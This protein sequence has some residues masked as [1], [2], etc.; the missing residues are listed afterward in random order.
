MARATTIAKTTAPARGKTSAASTSGSFAP[1]AADEASLDA[2]DLVPGDGIA[3]TGPWI[4]ESNAEGVLADAKRL[5][6]YWDSRTPSG[7]LARDVDDH[8][9][10]AILAALER[11]AK[12]DARPE[13]L[14][15]YMSRAALAAASK[16]PQRERCEDV[17]ARKVLFAWENTFAQENGRLATPA[18]RDD[19][20]AEIVANWP[21]KRHKPSA[22]FHSS[23]YGVKEVSLSDENAGHIENL[24]ARPASSQPR[25]GSLLDSAMDLVE[26]ENA[27]TADWFRLRRNAWNALAEINEAPMVT[28]CLGETQVRRARKVINADADVA[29]MLSAWRKGHLDAETEQ[30]LFSPWAQIDEEGK[31]QVATMLLGRRNLA[32]GL[33]DVAMKAASLRNAGKD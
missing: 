10:D 3:E 27:T 20:A 23:G 21:D 33:W 7:D 12:G 8:A 15:A 9:Q 25:P 14:K 11:Q 24:T 4:E 32:Y 26:K 22:R 30:H 2:L 19:A 28:P 18:E 6:R 1:I 31:D 17:Q 29:S 5:S 13:N 16:R